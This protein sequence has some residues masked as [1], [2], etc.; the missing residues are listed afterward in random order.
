MHVHGKDARRIAVKCP[1]AF[2]AHI[3]S[4]RIGFMGMKGTNVVLEAARPGGDGFF[5]FPILDERL[6]NE[7]EKSYLKH[8]VRSRQLIGK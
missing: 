6:V 7:T 1:G 8:L 4:M 5:M 3:T 2:T